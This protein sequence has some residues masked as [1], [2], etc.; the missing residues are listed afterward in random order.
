MAAGRQIN[1]P[2]SPRLAPMSL[3]DKEQALR[4]FARAP[5]FF[6]SLVLTLCFGRDDTPQRCVAPSAPHTVS[7]AP[8]PCQAARRQE[9]S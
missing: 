1:G 3:L 6:F 5:A 8:A 4:R 7:P 9:Q 2:C